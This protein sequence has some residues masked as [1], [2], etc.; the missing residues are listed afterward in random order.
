[1]QA[2]HDFGFLDDKN[3][4][5]VFDKDGNL[6]FPKVVQD[7]Q[8]FAATHSKSQFGTDI[9]NAFGI[10]GL[11]GAD[12]FGDVGDPQQLAS[13]LALIHGADQTEGVIAQQQQLANAPMQKFEQTI[14]RTGDLLNSA[15]TTLLPPLTGA[16]TVVNGTLQGVITALDVF[17]SIFASAPGD[18]NRPGRYTNPGALKAQQDQDSQ[19]W[20]TWWHHQFDNSA[21]PNRFHPAPAPPIPQPPASQTIDPA[22]LHKTA[23]EPGITVHVNGMNFY[24]AGQSAQDY[25]RQIADEIARELAKV[26][27]NNLGRGQGTYSSVYTSGI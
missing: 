24:G 18:P 4:L 12:I 22:L 2:L 21:F 15:V 5:T 9:Y 25:A 13:W 20:A 16:L 3:Q 17:N 1:L 19:S 10:R 7:L 23:Y 6:D 11:K 8:Q 14:A 27:I 26:Q